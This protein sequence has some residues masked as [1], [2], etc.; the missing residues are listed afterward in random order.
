MS[1]EPYSKANERTPK[2]WLFLLRVSLLALSVL[3]VILYI[4]GIPV[5]FAQLYPSN[6][7]C[8]QDCLTPANI[9]SLHALGLSVTAYAIYWVTI[10]LVFA[11]TYFAVAALIFWRKSDDGMALL[12]SRHPCDAG[13]HPSCLA[14]PCHFGK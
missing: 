4:V 1:H 6:H 13:S 12:A 3:N 9:Q 14:V 10:S 8:V 7:D 11:L 5:Y 2:G